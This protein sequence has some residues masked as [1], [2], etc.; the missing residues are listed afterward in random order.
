V[1]NHMILPIGGLLQQVTAGVQM[2]F[3]ENQ[4]LDFGKETPCHERRKK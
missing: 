2:H 4:I 1:Q 3:R